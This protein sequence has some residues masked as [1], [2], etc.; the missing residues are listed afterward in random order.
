MT[1]A[2]LI[3]LINRMWVNIRACH[4]TEP[5]DRRKYCELC[6]APYMGQETFKKHYH[7]LKEVLDKPILKLN[8]Y[9]GESMKAALLN[10]VKDLVKEIEINGLLEEV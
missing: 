4:F 7:R 5:N 9:I 3:V 10:Q 1:G 2:T 8:L 6:N